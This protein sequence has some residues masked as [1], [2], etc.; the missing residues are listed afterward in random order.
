M[1]LTAMSKHLSFLR[2]PEELY[3]EETRRQLKVKHQEIQ[4]LRSQAREASDPVEKA[5]LDASV[6]RSLKELSGLAYHREID[7]LL[8]FH[9][10]PDVAK[11]VYLFFVPAPPVANPSSPTDRPRISPFGFIFRDVLTDAMEPEVLHLRTES[12]DWLVQLQ[13]AKRMITSG[14]LLQAYTTM[15]SRFRVR[16]VNV[17]LARTLA[18]RMGANLFVDLHT[19]CDYTP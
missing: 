10:H 8:Q 1:S 14:E 19:L 2:D 17:L 12:E 6:L 9:Q 4:S 7:R 5:E 16:E 15:R 3:L 13:E 18:D 11:N